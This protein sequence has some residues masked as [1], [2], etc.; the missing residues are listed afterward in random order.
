MCLKQALFFVLMLNLTVEL[1]GFFFFWRASQKCEGL[2]GTLTSQR[3]GDPELKAAATRGG[4]GRAC[5]RKGRDLNPIENLPL[6][7]KIVK[8]EESRGN[9]VEEIKREDGGGSGGE[10]HTYG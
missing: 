7:L 2:K 6:C 9:D 8:P 4:R 5:E 3:A 10:N 1:D